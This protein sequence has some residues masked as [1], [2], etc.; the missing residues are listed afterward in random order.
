MGDHGQAAQTK[1]V[2]AAVGVRVEAGAHAPRRGPDQQTT[3]FSPGRGGDLLT[4]CVEKFP[5]RPLEQLEGNVAG[6]PV[7]DDDVG[8][9]PQQ[10]ARLGVAD[11]V[12][13]ACRH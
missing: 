2:R 6:E 1:Q 8:G 5:D 13:A 12:Q 11:E 3:E 10:V 9:A 7:S 4:Q